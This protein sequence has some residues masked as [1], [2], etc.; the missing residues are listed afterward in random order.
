MNGL[1]GAFDRPFSLPNI[2][3]SQII[4]KSDRTLVQTDRM[5]YA[6]QLL[7]VSERGD[8]VNIPGLSAD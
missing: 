7:V 8:P 6:V 1:N 2:Q 4:E 3:R 5:V